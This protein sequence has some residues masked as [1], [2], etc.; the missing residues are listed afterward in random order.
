[1]EEEILALAIERVL[2]GDYQL[3]D[4]QEILELVSKTIA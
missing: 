2:L 1:M 4:E 3:D